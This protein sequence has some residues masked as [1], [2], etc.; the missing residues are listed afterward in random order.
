MVKINQTNREEANGVGPSIADEI[1]RRA[2][3]A[4]TVRDLTKFWRVSDQTIYRLAASGTIPHFR[5]AGSIRF[6]PKEI[7]NWIRKRSINGM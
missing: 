5:L 2:P 6:D 7:A 1:A 4:L 3:N